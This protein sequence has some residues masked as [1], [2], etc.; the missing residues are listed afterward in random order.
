MGLSSGYGPAAETQEAIRLLRAAVERGVTFFDTAEG[1]V[2]LRS[3]AIGSYTTLRDTIRSARR[4]ERRWAS[5][6]CTCW[7]PRHRWDRC[8]PD[9]SSGPPSVNLFGTSFRD[10]PGEFAMD[11]DRSGYILLARILLSAGFVWSG[12]LKLLDPTAATAGMAHQGLP[13]PVLFAWLAIL[14]EFFGGL[15]LLLGMRTRTVALLFILY[16]IIAT[17]IGHRFW[18]FTGPAQVANR[19]NFEKNLAWMGGMLALW[20]TGGGRYALDAWIDERRSAR[21]IP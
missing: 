7:E 17:A 1:S 21:R 11:G 19:I 20:V 16:L 2:N 12:F 3:E 14:V 13:V 5:L 4:H 10:S 18:E 15:V 9:F 8:Y 6:R